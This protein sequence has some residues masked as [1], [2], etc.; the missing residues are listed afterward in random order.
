ML[1]CLLNCYYNLPSVASLQLTVTSLQTKKWQISDL[2]CIA[3]SSSN[4]SLTIVMT[5]DGN[6]SKLVDFY[7]VILQTNK[8]TM[9]IDEYNDNTV[10]WS[11]PGPPS[12]KLTVSGLIRANVRMDAT[13][14]HLAVQWTAS[15][16]FWRRRWAVRREDRDRLDCSLNWQVV[17]Q[18]LQN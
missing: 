7:L 12:E 6:R 15:C 14:L 13:F 16:R 11:W 3:W 18:Q 5:N 8:Q 2:E 1:L 9:N 17:K 10:T 4:F